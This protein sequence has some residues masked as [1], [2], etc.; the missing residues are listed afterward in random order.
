MAAPAPLPVESFP[1]DIQ[2]LFA[3]DGSLCVWCSRQLGLRIGDCTLDHVIP[4]SRG[5]RNTLDNYL[6]ACQRCNS[7]RK[8]KRAE[9]W[10]NDCERQGLLVQREI[11]ADALRR[12]DP[13]KVVAPSKLSRRARKER[14]KL[15]A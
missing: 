3:R 5:G 6:L 7:T 2:A 9:A 13:L 8:S 10:A 12:A 15:N 14:R 1:A 4:K 11:L